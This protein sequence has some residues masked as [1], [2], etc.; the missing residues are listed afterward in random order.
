MLNFKLTTTPKDPLSKFNIDVDG[1]VVEAFYT[2]K[3]WMLEGCLKF[4]T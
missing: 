2:R 3:W 4:Q 1:K